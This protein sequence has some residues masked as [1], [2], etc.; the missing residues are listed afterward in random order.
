MAST[1]RKSVG[2][3]FMTGAKLTWSFIQ[4]TG[5]RDERLLGRRKGQL[6][7]RS[8]SVFEYGLW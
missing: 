7:P 8:S 3:Q 6:C 5:V 4:S 2:M 1:V